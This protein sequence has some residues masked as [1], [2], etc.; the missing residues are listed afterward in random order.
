MAACGLGGALVAVA[1]ALQTGV[2]FPATKEQIVAA[3]EDVERDG[4]AV[5]HILANGLRDGARFASAREVLYE[6]ETW[7]LRPRA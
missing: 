2:R 1:Q 6:L 5:G 4:W 7:V 3:L